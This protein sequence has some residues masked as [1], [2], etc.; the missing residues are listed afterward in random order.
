[1]RALPR[2]LLDRL[3]RGG[4]ELRIVV[5]RLGALGDV[6]RTLSPVRLLRAHLPDAE[7]HWVVDDRWATVLDAHPDL[8]D[9]IRFP[10]SSWKEMSH[11]AGGLARLL[12]SVDRWTRALRARRPGLVIDFHGN[13]RSGLVALLSG[14]PVRLGHAGHQQKEG[15]RFFTT[16]RVPPGSRRTPRME[17]N[18]TLVQALGVPDRPLPDGGL[19]VVAEKTG[20]ARGIVASLVGP[21]RPYAVL[22]PGAS[23]KQAYKKPPAPLLAAAARQIASRGIAS[24]VVYGPGEEAD[25]EEIVRVAASGACRTPPTDLHVLAALLREA[26]LFVGGD[27]GPLHL[28]CAVGC[29]VLGLYGP[30]DPE[31]N[32]P[33]GVPKVV[34]CPPGRFYTGIKSRDRASGSFA[35][36]E[37][38]AVRAGVDEMLALVRRDGA[39]QKAL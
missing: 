18:L 4:R 10:R 36:L 29:P 23:R 2:D 16:H 3:Q 22:S 31:V 21:D 7:I 1:M 13:L 20:A 25:A 19:P 11:S 32:A 37:P 24:L 6:L 17:R 28:A 8:D 34:L 38:E 26:R 12:P 39:S 30:T 35:G 9:V 27:S 14:A 33:W 5:L 15:N